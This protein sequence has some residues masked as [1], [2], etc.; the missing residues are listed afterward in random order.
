MDTWVVG[1]MA[2][3]VI[4]VVEV[5][6]AVL[7]GDAGVDPMEGARVAIE[8]MEQKRTGPM[9]CLHL[10]LFLFLRN[11]LNLWRNKLSW[12]HPS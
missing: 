10:Q 12:S 5:P 2:E 1:D 9:L 6:D 11:N 7:Q 4:E 3:L 8:K